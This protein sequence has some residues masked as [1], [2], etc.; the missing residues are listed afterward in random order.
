L[1]EFDDIFFAKMWLEIFIRII[2]FH[3][4]EGTLAIFKGDSF[5]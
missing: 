3:C 1:H 4:P 2:W 5:F